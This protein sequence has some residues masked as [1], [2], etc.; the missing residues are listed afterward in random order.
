MFSKKWWGKTF[1][2]MARVGAYTLTV[3]IGSD[4]TGLATLDWTFIAQSTGLIMLLSL[5]GSIAAT[6]L[7]KDR[8][9]PGI[10]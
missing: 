6:N 5:L 8:E 1:E 9:D 4:A 7:G 2:R 10:L 3:M